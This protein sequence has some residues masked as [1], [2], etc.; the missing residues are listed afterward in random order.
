MNNIN[1]TLTLEL[2]EKELRERKEKEISE[3]KNLFSKFNRWQQA[4][5]LR[6]YI[7]AIEEKNK[8]GRE[9]TR[10]QKEWIKWAKQKADWYDPLIDKEDPLLG[11]FKLELIEEKKDRTGYYPGYFY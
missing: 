4:R 2:I 5:N 10:E 7:T 3:F 9:L 11:P 8:R 6:E 1:Y